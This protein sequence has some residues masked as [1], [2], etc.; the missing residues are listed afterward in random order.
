MKGRLMSRR[1]SLALLLAAFAATEVHA[2]FPGPVGP[3]VPVVVPNGVGFRYRG[4]NLSV[5]GFFSTGGYGV[6]VLPAPVFVPGPVPVVPVVPY[7]PI[8]TAGYVDSRVS[9]TVVAPVVTLPPRPVFGVEPVDLSGVDLDLAPSPLKA[10]EP[11]APPRGAL[12]IEPRPPIEPPVKEPIKKVDEPKKK[13]EKP[14][15]KEEPKIETP[16]E[17]GVRAFG[18]GAYALAEFHFRQVTEAEPAAGR[19]FFLLAQSLIAQ[20]RFR[21]AVAAIHTGLK[22][23]PDF[24]TAAFRPRLDLYKGIEPEFMRHRKMLDDLV[25]ENPKNGTFRFLQGYLSWFDDQRDEARKTFT[26]ARPLVADPMFIDLFLKAAPGP[27][28]LR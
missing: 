20:G 10:L 1:C 5:S 23:A 26:A 19:P 27:V 2:Q 16:L 9:Y 15:P 14:A 11:K 28:A 13:V 18:E 8:P 24:P 17:Q 4:R 6:G 12:K 7:Y 22:N 25:V 3:G 21:D